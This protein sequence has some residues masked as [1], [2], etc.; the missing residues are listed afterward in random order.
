VGKSRK[1]RHVDRNAHRA[2]ASVPPGH[3]VERRPA[4]AAP[5]P[6][7]FPLRPPIAASAIP[8]P[9]IDEPLV[10]FRKPPA[11]PPDFYSRYPAKKTR[12]AKLPDPP[13]PRVLPS[14]P[15]V[16]D[17]PSTPPPPQPDMVV[18]SAPPVPPIL[19]LT[20][21]PAPPRHLW[22]ANEPVPVAETVELLEP[23]QWADEIFMPAPRPAPIV[24]H[25]PTPEQEAAAAS[26]LPR[27][28]AIT[29]W[30]KSGP[31]D[32]IGHWLRTCAHRL[33]LRIAPAGRRPSE[34][35]RLRAENAHLRQQLRALERRQA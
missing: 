12:K 13:T 9:R 6:V 17:R 29:S 22:F 23:M 16:M 25:V 21:Q 1:H 3:V 10:L 2:M 7:G 33:A 14:Q 18:P 26:P 8:L 24:H 34:L 4:Q 5:P 28:A 32:A 20:F 30:K 19:L 27:R 15:A 11:A 31:L 35:V